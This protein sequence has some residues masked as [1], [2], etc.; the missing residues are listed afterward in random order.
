MPAF[1]ITAHDQPELLAGM[2][3]KLSPHPVFVHIN[4]SVSISP[5]EKLLSSY[6]HVSLV[7]KEKSIQTS[8]GG[9]SLVKAQ[10]L[11]LNM[12]NESIDSNDYFVSLTGRDFPIKPIS[13][14]Q[15][16]LFQNL[17][18]QHIGYFEIQRDMRD[19]QVFIQN[20]YFYDY[21]SRFVLDPSDSQFLRRII[22]KTL[23][24]KFP[25]PYAWSHFSRTNSIVC[26][27]PRF[28]VQKSIIEGIANTD[29]ESAEKFFKFGHAPD[30]MFFHTLIHNSEYKENCTPGVVSYDG[31]SILSLKKAIP[32]F[33]CNEHYQHLIDDSALE[34]LK[35]CDSFFA[36]KFCINKS[37]KVLAELGI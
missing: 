11:M 10:L 36:R 30:D 15:N 29:I 17:N 19:F 32:H 35:T 37:S 4:Q 3:R 25:K 33:W 34:H 5:F 8:W 20:M 12:A 16:F 31:S 22:N 1:L 9:F 18:K 24:G 14:F 2:V 28:A 27:Y 26:G 21:V 7:P 6:D 23:N 13:H